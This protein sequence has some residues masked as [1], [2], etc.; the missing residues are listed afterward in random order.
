[1]IIPVASLSRTDFKRLDCRNDK[2]DWLF[3]ELH[4]TTFRCF[5]WRGFDGTLF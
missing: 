5:L 3:P 4:Q 2:G 1:M